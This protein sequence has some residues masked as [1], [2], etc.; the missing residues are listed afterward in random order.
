MY[1]TMMRTIS[2]LLPKF[3]A[4]IEEARGTIQTPV[5]EANLIAFEQRWN[6]VLP[7]DMREFYATMNGTGDDGETVT[8]Y[9]F[10]IWPL[11]EVRPISKMEP[12]LSPADAAIEDAARYLCFSDYLL[13][14][15]VYAIHAADSSRVISVCAGHRQVATSFTDFVKRLV[16]DFATLL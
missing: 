16:T 13:N 8:D 2:S 7:A 11:D 10:R 6:I 14:S 1:S 3:I 9:L 12:E 4:L 5:A 15:D